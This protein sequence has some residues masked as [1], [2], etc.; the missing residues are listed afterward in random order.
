MHQSGLFSV[1]LTFTS[2]TPHTSPRWGQSAALAVVRPAEANRPTALHR[3]LVSECL[4]L[5]YVFMVSQR[6][7]GERW[8]GGSCIVPPGFVFVTPLR[9]VECFFK[10]SPHG[11]RVETRQTH[12]YVLFSSG[13]SSVFVVCSHRS[14]DTIVTGLGNETFCPT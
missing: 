5:F 6:G 13:D 9:S 11:C 12:V 1:V 4:L 3:V 8:Q 2:T 14:R 10:P 7:G